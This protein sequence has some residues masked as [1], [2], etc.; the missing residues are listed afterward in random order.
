MLAHQV[1]ANWRVAILDKADGP[2]PVVWSEK[3]GE[4]KDVW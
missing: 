2:I 4:Y 1:G 3:P